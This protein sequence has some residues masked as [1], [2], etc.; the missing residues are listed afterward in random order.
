MDS[1]F[2]HG[3]KRLIRTFLST[4]CERALNGVATLKRLYAVVNGE[5][6]QCSTEWPNRN[7]AEDRRLDQLEFSTNTES[8]EQP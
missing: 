8:V 6:D 4:Q 7:E 1:F 5:L 2:A 3:A